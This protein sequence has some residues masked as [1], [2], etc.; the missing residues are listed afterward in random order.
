[1][2]SSTISRDDPTG[3]GVGGT[4]VRVV[5]VRRREL[6]RVVLRKKGLPI[7]PGIAS[8]VLNDMAQELVDSPNFA[9]GRD[10][11][12]WAN[13]VYR[14]AASATVSA[15]SPSSPA[16]V[17][18]FQ[19]VRSALDAF[20]KKKSAP[21]KPSQSKP[22]SSAPLHFATAEPQLG[23]PPPAVTLAEPFIEVVEPV[24]EEVSFE[25]VDPV[26]DDSIYTLLEEAASELGYSIEA[27]RDMCAA[28]LFQDDIL[29]HIKEKTNKASTEEIKA[30]LRPQCP[31][32]LNK[33]DALIRTK[34]EEEA[35]IKA[36]EEAKQEAEARRKRREQIIRCVACG[37]PTCSFMPRVVGYREVDE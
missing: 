13:E 32:L 16:D 5:R 11:N 15:A 26:D 8:P 22:T 30:A 20:L 12:T 1:M 23:A 37:S 36:E 17:A 27:T 28:E 18:T 35:R 21:S 14:N 29:E 34:A 24:L 7:D 3:R 2:G 10:I 31:A 4:P 6:L 19:Y 25:M 9:N 33:M